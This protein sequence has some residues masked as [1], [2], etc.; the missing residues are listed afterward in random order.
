MLFVDDRGGGRLLALG[1]PMRL[2]TTAAAYPEEKQLGG[3]GVCFSSQIQGTVCHSRGV[4]MVSRTLKPPG[5][6]HPWPS[7]E[8][9]STDILASHAWLI[10]CLYGAG[11]KPGTVQSTV[12]WVFP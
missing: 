1:A 7:S 11:P 10:L 8:Q 6:P 5:K 12:S 4:G 9:M 2:K 3:E